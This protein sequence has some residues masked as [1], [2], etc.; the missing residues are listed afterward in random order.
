MNTPLASVGKLLDTGHR[1]V[2]DEDGSYAMNTRTRQVMRVRRERNVFVVDV[3]L[4]QDGDGDVTMGE[5]KVESKIG[6]PVFNRQ[7]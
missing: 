2:L 7:A 5:S 1:V 6:Q 3:W 4:A